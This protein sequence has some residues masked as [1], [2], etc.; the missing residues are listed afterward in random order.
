[1]G[2][3]TCL[4]PNYTHMRTAAELKVREVLSAIIDE[5]TK[6]IEEHYKNPKHDPDASASLNAKRFERKLNFH[7]D[8]CDEV[9]AML[10]KLNLLTR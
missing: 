4:Q 9:R 10:E 6:A 3:N 8:M 5:H 1:M 7:R 2:Q